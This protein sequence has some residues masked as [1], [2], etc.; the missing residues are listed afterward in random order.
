LYATIERAAEPDRRREQDAAG[1]RAAPARGR[2]SDTGERNPATHIGFEIS[3]APVRA[4]VRA[5]AAMDTTAAVR[6]DESDQRL[7]HKTGDR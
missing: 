2:R 7:Y 6:L 4:P 1:E 3:S 5:M